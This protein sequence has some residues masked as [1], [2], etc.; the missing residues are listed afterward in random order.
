MCAYSNH[1]SHL[2][3]IKPREKNQK[4]IKGFISDNE[5]KRAIL[6]SIGLSKHVLIKIILVSNSILLIFFSNTAHIIT[7]N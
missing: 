5:N 3:A 4:N 6:R 1:I 7:R 2:H